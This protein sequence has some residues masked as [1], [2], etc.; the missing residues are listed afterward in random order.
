MAT[1]SRALSRIKQDLQPIVSDADILDAC[2][3]AGHRWRQRLLDPVTTVHLFVL[4]ILHFNTALTHL[5]HLAKYPVKPAAFCKARM[6]L[7]LSVLQSL[8]A[9]T[10]AA[11]RSKDV[12]PAWNGLRAYLVDGSST[13]C[14]DTPMLQKAFGQPKNQK[15]GCGFPVPKLL[16]LFDAFS[17]MILELLVAPLYTADLTGAWQLHGLLRPGD[18]LVGDRG[19]CSF[20]HL[21]ILAEKGLHGLFRL[22][23]RVIV[24]FKPYRKRGGTGR[25]TSTFVKRLGPLDQIVDWHK[26]ITKATWMTQ[27]QHEALPAALRVRELRYRLPKKGQRTRVVTIATTLLDPVLYPYELIAR[28]YGVRWTVETHFGELK[29]TLKMRRIKCKT[30]A[31]VKKELA[32]YC[33]VYNLVHAVML[34]AARRQQVSPRRISFLDTIRWLLSAAPGEDLPGL[35]VNPY[36]PDRHEPRVIKDKLDTYRKMVK[37]RHILKQ[38]LHLW[39][40]KPK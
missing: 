26:P 2:R 16:G 14:P 19:F 33:L 32:V 18:L 34:E 38:E 5:R 21:A 25:P 4:Q 20:G 23:Q 3:Q 39:G 30:V 36:R 27:T 24:S 31:G 10:A 35:L 11:A 9:K 37:P 8:L 29:T 22:H 13:I 7:P 17:G 28:L 40:G 15:V 12:P 6:R 1:V